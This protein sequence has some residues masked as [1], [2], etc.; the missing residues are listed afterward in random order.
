M[1]SAPFSLVI[2]EDN[3][4]I[5]KIV[6][7]YFKRSAQFELLFSAQSTEAFIDCWNDQHIDIILCDIGL[8]GKSGLEATR[9]AKSISPHTEVVM[10]SVSDDEETVFKA[11]CAGASGYLLKDTP[12]SKVEDHLVEVVKGGA[13][14]SPAVA[15]MVVG[16][17]NPLL[18]KPEGK[19]IDA[20]TKHELEVAMLLQHG[21]TYRAVA[22][23]L[24]IS[25][26]TVKLHIRN[27]YSKLQVTLRS[28]L[29]K[30]F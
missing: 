17:F 7:E 14:M 1:N 26:D 24:F 25:V 22:E 8:P 13:A 12:L 29:V 9:Y 20:L 10:F 16:Y 6:T 27:I 4:L 3:P 21:A 15:R 30:G 11:L 5:S 18:D 19:D 2:I 28:E 23:Q